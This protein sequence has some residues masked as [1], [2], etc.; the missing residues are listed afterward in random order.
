MSYKYDIEKKL[1]FRE[2]SQDEYNNSFISGSYNYIMKKLVENKIMSKIEVIGK[3]MIPTLIPNEKVI[4]LP[5]SYRA[6]A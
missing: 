3:S 6:E 5:C 2:E 4:I 1:L